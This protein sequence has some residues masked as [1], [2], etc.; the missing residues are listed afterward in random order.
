[1]EKSKGEE[2]R[3]FSI[4]IPQWMYDEL[5][6]IAQE[7]ARSLNKQVF[8]YLKKSIELELPSESKR[9]SSDDQQVGK[10]MTANSQIKK[11]KKIQ[12]GD[13]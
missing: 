8:L 9:A 2:Y 6:E 5:S 12:R 13:G 11:E 10:E 7:Q 4:R 1:M 3:T